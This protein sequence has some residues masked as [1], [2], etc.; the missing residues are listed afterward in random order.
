[1]DRLASA[2][3][4][5]EIDVDGGRPVLLGLALVIGVFGRE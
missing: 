2:L 1:V 4:M 3:K 5:D